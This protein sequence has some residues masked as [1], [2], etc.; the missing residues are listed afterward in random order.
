VTF[1]KALFAEDG[2]ISMMRVLSL[3][4]LLIGGYLAVIGHD[5]SV[6]LFVVSAFSGKAIQKAIELHKP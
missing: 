3:V 1:L 6:S 4:S 2:S 5:T